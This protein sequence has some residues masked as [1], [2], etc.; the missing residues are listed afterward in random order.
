MKL[1]ILWLNVLATGEIELTTGKK[2]TDQALFVAI[3]KTP[4]FELFF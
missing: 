2:F 4:D 1:L 3:K